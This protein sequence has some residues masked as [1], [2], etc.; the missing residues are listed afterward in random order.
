MTAKRTGFMIS[1][2]TSDT[3]GVGEQGVTCEQ[4]KESFYSLRANARP[5]L[6]KN[7]SMRISLLVVKSLN[8]RFNSK[9]VIN[10]GIPSNTIT[11][12]INIGSG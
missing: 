8:G 11:R 4:P 5:N 10:R 1:Q 2:M 6:L 7:R 12:V 9:C 3:V